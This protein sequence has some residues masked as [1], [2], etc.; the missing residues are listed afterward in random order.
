MHSKKILPLAAAILILLTRCGVESGQPGSDTA[1]NKHS[2]T[3]S[4]G[5]QV[6]PHEVKDSIKNGEHIERYPNGVI[7]MKG[8]VKN[9]LREGV[10]LSFY[11]D[12][13]LWSEGVYKDGYR[14]GHGVSYFANGKKSSEGDYSHDRM[15]GHWVFWNEYGDSTLKDYGK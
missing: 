4:G 12:G 7:Y 13:K 6:Q 3:V 8:E 5:G 11:K 15:V 2:M 14:E 1:G 10:W 9:G